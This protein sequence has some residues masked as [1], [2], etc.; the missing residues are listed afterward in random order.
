MERSH[1]HKVDF[2]IIHEILDGSLLVARSRSPHIRVE[3][4]LD[5]QLLIRRIPDRLVALVT[6]QDGCLHIVSYHRPWHPTDGGE[7]GDQTAQPRLLPHILL[8][9][10][11]HITTVLVPCT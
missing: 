1:R 9:T 8:V 5:G 11:A 3:F 4:E 6:A 7:T 2:H 10:D